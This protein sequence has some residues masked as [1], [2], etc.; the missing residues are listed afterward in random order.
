MTENKDDEVDKEKEEEDEE[1]GGD[2]VTRD[3][4]E[5]EESDQTEAQKSAPRQGEMPMSENQQS[6][7][8]TILSYIYI[9]E[10]HT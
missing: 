4:E 6:H 7:G 10:L 9:Y 1:E 2:N 3:N 5:E 8:N